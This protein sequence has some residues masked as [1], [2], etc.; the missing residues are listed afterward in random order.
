MSNLFGSILSGA[1]GAIIILIDLAFAI[2]AGIGKIWYAYIFNFILLFMAS[3][4]INTTYIQGLT[5]G[6]SYIYLYGRKRIGSALGINVLTLIFFII[7]YFI[8]RL[9]FS[10]PIQYLLFFI[11]CIVLSTVIAFVDNKFRIAIERT[12]TFESLKYK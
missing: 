9:V 12:K 6:Y 7:A 3:S 5:R 8:L 10:E 1:S 2:W 4:V 11:V